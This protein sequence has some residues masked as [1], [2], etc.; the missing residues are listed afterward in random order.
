M[1][2]L[3]TRKFFEKDIEYIKS[4]IKKNTNKLFEIIELDDYSEETIVARC[5]EAD[6]LLGSFVSD[7]IIKQAVNL[8]LIQI[9]WTGLDAVDFSSLKNFQGTICNSHSNAT[10]VAEFA[11]ALTLDLVK[12]I[13]YH[14]SLMRVGD[15]NRANG[16]VSLSSIN[17]LNANIGIMGYGAIGSKIGKIVK[18]FGANVY[19]LSKKHHFDSEISK[20]YLFSDCVSFINSVDIIICCLPLTE[21]TKDF[22]NEQLFRQISNPLYIIN[23]SRAEIFNQKALYTALEHEVVS[24]YASDVW[25]SKTDEKYNFLQLDNVVLSPHR[26]GYTNESLPHLDDVIINLARLMNG[27]ELINIVDVAKQY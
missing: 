17:L 15:L 21:E 23:I 24:G 10:A 1:N 4:G 5:A 14:D 22:F 27:D 6:V 26:A 20:S 18:A 16:R 7:E 12:K 3:T 8:K 9:P 13:T 25:W 11:I 2:I 19:S